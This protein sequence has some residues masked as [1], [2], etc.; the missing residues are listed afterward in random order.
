VQ[1]VRPV[2]G[3]EVPPIEMQCAVV[4]LVIR[5][6]MRSRCLAVADVNRGSRA[7]ELVGPWQ[8]AL[9]GPLQRRCTHSV[10]N[11][12]PHIQLCDVSELAD[13]GNSVGSGIVFLS[14]AQER[15]VALQP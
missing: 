3:V 13:E 6:W 9:L 15:I 4:V 1:K 8:Q 7:T 14:E 11:G 2:M 5:N 10:G 12:V